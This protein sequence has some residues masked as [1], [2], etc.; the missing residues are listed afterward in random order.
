[1]AEFT[2]WLA[3]LL[4]CYSYF[5]YPLLLWLLGRNRPA[6]AAT[7]TAGGDIGMTL[8]V[9]AFNERQRIGPKLEN[10]L[11]IDYPG[12]Q[13]IVASDCSTDGTDDLVA[14]YAGRGIALARTAD[15]GGKERAQQHA[16]AGATGEV[17]VFSDVATT[18]PPDALRLLARYFHDA[19]IGA[20]SSE[21]R[22]VGRDDRVV[23][24]GAYVRYEMWLRRMESSIGG[25]IGLSGSF[26]AARR[27]LCREWDSLS[28]SD[29]NTALQCAR[30]GLRAITAPDVI[31][32]Y[33]DL[34]DP[35]REYQ[36]KVRTVLRGVTA[37]VRHR[38]V[39][40]IGRHGLF[41]LQMWSHK[42]MR[43][44]VP[45]L[46]ALVLVLNL[47]L[48]RSSSAYAVLL[49]AQLC[50]YGAALIGHVSARARAW[51]PIRILYY[52]VQA[53]VAIVEA[54]WRYATGTRI[55]VWKP[56]AR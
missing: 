29:F 21:D 13:I 34:S 18:I 9:T 45:F 6:L 49:A 37:L 30:S 5:L 16:L 7:G 20:V 11:A 44:A 51:G 42:V 39:L 19:R 46:L 35:Q 38:D 12:L 55:T 10:S 31:G 41:A 17:V 53:N 40:N 32:V 8:I 27:A 50:F 26:F 47:H 24:E 4:A 15:R 23:G 25:L 56:S 28:P 54:C 2:F 1:M 52:F 36:R 48:A 22:L 33:Q 43:W 14:G 3:L